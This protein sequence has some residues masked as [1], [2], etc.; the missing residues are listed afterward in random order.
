ME[1]AGALLGFVL[2]GAV[3]AG[4]VAWRMS[5]RHSG[6]PR[7]WQYDQSEAADLH[8]RMYRR[9]DE[10]RRQSASAA[11]RGVPVDRVKDL[12][13]DLDIEAK[14]VDAQLVAASRLPGQAKR[15]S[16]LQLRTRIVEVEGLADRVAELLVA[17]EAPD[18]A[19][20]DVGL[21]R[22]RDSLDALDAARREAREIGPEGTPGT[23][24]A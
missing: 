10:L 9:L 7:G 21:G 6:V 19:D 22:V 11:R 13:T 16:L 24:E 3:I 23:L 12:I 17:L 14:A 20:I 1:I 15:K 5:R 4:L 8:R 2:L 18:A